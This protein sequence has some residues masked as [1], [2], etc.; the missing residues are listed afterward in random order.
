MSDAL[1]TRFQV[2]QL[3]LEGTTLDTVPWRRHGKARIY[4]N[5][6]DGIRIDPRLQAFLEW[7]T[8]A[9]ADMPARPGLDPATGMR[10]IVRPVRLAHKPP[11][12]SVRKQLMYRIL[13]QLVAAGLCPAEETPADWRK[14][15]LRQAFRTPAI[16]AARAGAAPEP[17][18]RGTRIIRLLPDPAPGSKPGPAGSPGSSVH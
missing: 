16:T 7:R 13:K 15:R 3:R 12:V 14:V 1:P 11:L 2:A 8:E 18:A 17:Q 6:V 10:L 4:I 9:E 5:S